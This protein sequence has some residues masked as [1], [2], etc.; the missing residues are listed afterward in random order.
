MASVNEGPDSSEQELQEYRTAD[1]GTAWS[2]LATIYV[3]G[4]D[5]SNRSTIDNFSLS[6]IGIP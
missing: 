4:Y 5:I 3:F 1:G 6:K 2:P